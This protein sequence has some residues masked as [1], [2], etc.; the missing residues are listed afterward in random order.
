VADFLSARAG[1]APNRISVSGHADT[2]PVD[3]NT[4]PQGRS[5]NRRIEVIVDG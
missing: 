4:T 3:N 5:R 1:V 2:R